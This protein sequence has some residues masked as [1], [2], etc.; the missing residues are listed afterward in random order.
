MLFPGQGCGFLKKEIN[1]I[2][3]IRVFAMMMVVFVHVTAVYNQLFAVDTIQHM[4]YHFINRL[5]RVE[6]GLFIML[7]GIVFFY[8]YRHK[9]MDGKELLNYFK[10]RVVYILIPYIIWSLIYEVDALYFN[11]REFDVKSIISNILHG[12]SNYQLHFISLIV[13]FYLLFPIFLYLVQKF[14]FLKKH[15][16]LIGFLVEFIYFVLNVKYRFTSGPSFITIL[17]PFLL[18]AWFGLHYEKVVAKVTK[19]RTIAAGI[20]FLLIAIPFILQRYQT[21]FHSNYLLPVEFERL[22][23]ITFLFIGSAFFF[24]LSERLASRSAAATT[25]E[26]KKIAFYSFGFYLLHPFIITRIRMYIPIPDSGISWHLMIFVH[27][28][29][30]ILICYFIIWFFH[31]FV[32]YSSFLF[33]KLPKNA[34]LIGQQKKSLAVK[35]DENY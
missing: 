28:F 21:S 23:E 17:S 2:Y 26:I 19:F 30:V 27:Y 31:R 9:K 22:L 35:T 20:A 7:V 32:P 33:G 34:A 18:G 1:S 10:K 12:K 25:G 6:A 29:L 15:L 24:Y 14:S 11:M 5:V 8:N 16:W 4:T 3:Y 13:Q